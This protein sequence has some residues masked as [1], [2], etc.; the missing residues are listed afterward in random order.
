MLEENQYYLDIICEH[1][2]LYKYILKNIYAYFIFKN[3]L[4]VY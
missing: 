2:Y 4:A 3:V 1:Q